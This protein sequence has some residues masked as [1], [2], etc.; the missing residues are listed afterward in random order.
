MQVKK[1]PAEISI[2][3]LKGV[4][5]QKSLLFERLGI[6][7]ISDLFYYLPRRYEDRSKIVPISEIEPGNT[8]TVVGEVQKTSFFRAKTGTRIFEAAIADGNRRVFAVWYNQPYMRGVFSKGDKVMLYGKVE[9]TKRL[10]ISHPVF[11]IIDEDKKEESLEM[12]RIV[13]VYSL[14]EDIT[15][16]YLRNVVNQAIHLYSSQVKDPL[17]TSLR[18]RRKLVDFKFALENIH[19]PHSFENLERAYKRLVFEEF[20]ILQVVMALKRK[21]FKADG[22]KHNTS[23]NLLKDFEDLFHFDFT[24]GQKKCIKDIEKDMIEEKPMYRLLQGDVG[25]GKTVIAM[26]ALLLA[27]SSGYQAAVMAPTEILARQHYV[28]ISKTFM[29]LGLNVR[30]LISGIEKEDR[31]KIKKELAQGE[32]DIV[33]GTHSLFQEDINYDRLGFVVIDEQHKFGVSQRDTLRKKGK[34]PDTLV[35][36]ATPIPRSLALT[37]YGDMDISLLKEKPVE[38]GEITTYWVGD[39]RRE[40]VYKFLRDEVT[41]GRQAFLVYPRISRTD[42]SDLL[43]IEEMYKHLKKDVFPDLRLGALHGK[44][45]TDDKKNTMEDFRNK[46][47]DILLATT[48]V[49]VGIDVPNATV[50]VVEHAERYGLAQLHQLRGRIGR[51]KHASYCIL[52]SEPT[53]D[54]SSERLAAMTQTTDGFEIAERDLDIRGPGEFFGTRQSGLPEIRLGNIVKD[55]DIM[56]EARK[57][58]FD[59]VKEDP[60]LKDE[61]HAGIKENIKERFRGKIEI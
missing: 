25:S 53:T 16:R 55:F 15:Q 13:P 48:V 58:A 5:P 50:M 51:S 52:I 1:D 3:Y 47:Y 37:I 40:L 23:E 43:S 12:G 41:K 10:Q 22:I 7:N 36:T 35:V 2:R 61:H 9:L 34:M 56:E 24:E 57:E 38:R 18:A 45:K 54:S 4:G 33:I 60:D 31:E 46:K 14:T 39:D 21:S 42:N 20:F 32:V 30:L 59:L 44:M 29:P 11:E 17:P 27:V 28:T 49:E 6:E 8:H 26:Y 19:F